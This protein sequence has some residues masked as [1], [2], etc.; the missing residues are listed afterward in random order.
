MSGFL[1]TAFD[2]MC[3]LA[4]LIRDRGRT[5]FRHAFADIYESSIEATTYGRLGP[6][7]DRLFE[8]DGDEDRAGGSTKRN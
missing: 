4:F 3:V 5:A 1:T 6:V 7:N 8:I 2:P